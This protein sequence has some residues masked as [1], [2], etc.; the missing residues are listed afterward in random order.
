MKYERFEDDFMRD[1]ERQV[2]YVITTGMALIVGAIVF[3]AVL[4]A[5]FAR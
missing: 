2:M 1:T 5:M 4:V 3:G